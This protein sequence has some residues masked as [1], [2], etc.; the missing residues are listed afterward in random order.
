MESFDFTRFALSRN[1]DKGAIDED[2]FWLLQN[3]H[4]SKNFKFPNKHVGG[5]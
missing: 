4:H 1:Y 3:L 2:E 5:F